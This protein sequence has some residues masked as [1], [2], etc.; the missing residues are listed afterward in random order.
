MPWT[1]IDT[2][3][4]GFF[5]SSALDLMLYKVLE[6]SRITSIIEA[7]E[8]RTGSSIHERKILE[9]FHI[10]H[11]RLCQCR[12]RCLVDSEQD[13]IP[14]PQCTFRASEQEDKEAV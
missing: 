12:E 13:F 11:A 8:G 1:I 9:M 6:P 4:L 3:I 14:S 5:E 7:T 10:N 2:P